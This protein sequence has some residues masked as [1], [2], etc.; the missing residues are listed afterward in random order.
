MSTLRIS[1]TVLEWLEIGRVA[2]VTLSSQEC[3]LTPTFRTLTLLSAQAES[4]HQNMRS[5]SGHNHGDCYG[6]PWVGWSS[7][8]WAAPPLPG[9]PSFFALAS[10]IETP[11]RL[12]ARSA[13]WSELGNGLAGGRRSLDLNR[14]R[15]PSWQQCAASREPELRSGRPWR[16]SGPTVFANCGSACLVTGPGK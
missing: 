10:R 13:G 3:P 6:V 5:T 11:I 14:Y 12:A 9:A 8:P 7:E 16:K 1:T 15:V 4:G 2:A